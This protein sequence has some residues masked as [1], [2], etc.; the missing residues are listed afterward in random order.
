MEKK[1]PRTNVGGVSLSRMI[2]GTNWILGYSHTSNAADNFIKRQN[3]TVEAITSILEVFLNSGVD[4]IMGPFAGNRQLIDAVRAAEDRMGKK[5]I[6][7][8]TPI[9]NVDDNAMARKEAE[10]V[11]ALSKRIGAT[12]CLPHHTSVEQL[13]NKNKKTIERLPDYLKMIRDHDMIPG[14]S[15]HMP[16]LI[17]YSDLNGYDVETYIQIYNCAGFLMQVEIEYVHK[18]IW[19]AKKPVMTIK[20]MAAGRVS[21]FVGLTF[22]WHTIRPCDMVTVGCLTP[23][24]AEEDIEIS[25][26]ALEGRPPMLEG[27][28]SPNK[29]EIMKNPL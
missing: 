25:L 14:L 16:E 12:F 29:T 27:R 19:S 10:E 13:V 15:C 9:I 28:D 3:S 6:I 26:A 8:D 2:I 5:M 18:I 20:P 17:V 1:F 23:E 24:E 11:I 21:P 4:T 7:I 22:S